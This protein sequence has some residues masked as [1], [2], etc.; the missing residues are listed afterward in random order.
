MMW[1]LYFVQQVPRKDS[2]NQSCD[3]I[4]DPMH[5]QSTW[6]GGGGVT[7]FAIKSRQINRAWVSLVCA[8]QPNYI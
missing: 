6:G 5:S 1:I 2:K 7:C 8:T 3:V 4:R